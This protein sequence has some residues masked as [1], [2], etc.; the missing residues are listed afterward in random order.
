MATLRKFVKGNLPGRRAQDLAAR[1]NKYSAA[2]MKKR[3]TRYIAL[4]FANSPR[5][6]ARCRLVCTWHC[7]N[8]R[9]D[10]DNIASAKKFILDGLQD[11]G[12][13]RNDGWKQIAGFV[14]NFVVD[15]ANPGVEIMLIEVANKGETK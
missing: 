12:V 5:V 4:N 10:P 11:A 1:G 14:D 9:Q 15:K 7:E 3:W 13:L 8:K 2:S 6:D